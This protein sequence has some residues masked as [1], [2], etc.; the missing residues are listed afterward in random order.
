MPKRDLMADL[1]ATCDMIAA[2]LGSLLLLV[3]QLPDGVGD[4]AR[5]VGLELAPY[6]EILQQMGADPD[7]PIPV[8]ANLPR[9]RRRAATLVDNTM[10][11]GAPFPA[12]IPPVEEQR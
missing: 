1:G 11:D 2:R 10:A 7:N 3:A 5:A 8:P 12:P 9:T 4:E 6:V